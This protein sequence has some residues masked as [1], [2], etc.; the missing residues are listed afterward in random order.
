MN[1]CEYAKID[2]IR[3][4]IIR[5]KVGVTFVGIWSKK[6]VEMVRTYKENVLKLM[7]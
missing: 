7:H 5:D 4:N 2:E 6:R 1:M 3:N